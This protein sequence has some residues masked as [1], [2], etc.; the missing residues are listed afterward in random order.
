MAA[1][2]P[3]KY[4]QYLPAIFQRK[5]AFE[6]EPVLG[7]FLA[8]FE[9]RFDEFEHIMAEV[10]RKFSA[11]LAPAGDFLPWLAGWVAHLFD[12]EWDE[13]RRRRFLAGAMEL[14]RWRGTT[15]GLKRYLD[16]WLDLG[17][18]EV[19]IR[20]GRWPAGM[21]IG[22]ASRI[23]YGA[24]PGAT[25][26]AANGP[27]AY[28]ARNAVIDWT[29]H[30][31]YVVDTLASAHLQPSTAESSPPGATGV[32]GTSESLPDGERMQLYFDTDFVQR[33][34]LLKDGDG[35]PAGVRLDYL[36]HDAAG[37]RTPRR[38][39][40]AS[41]ANLKAANR[42][43]VSRRDGL[44]DYY[45]SPGGEASPAGVP[46]AMAGGALL[47]TDVE[48]PYCFIV[49]IRRAFPQPAGTAL[50]E[51]EKAKALS[52]EIEKLGRKV[53]A[54]L[55]AERPAHTEYFVRITPAAG[56][57]G[58]NFMQIGEYSTIGLDTTVA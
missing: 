12:E 4:L 52:V 11:S 35:K 16:L 46:R 26:D 1:S 37:E 15:A 30:N 55:D 23:G 13:D 57:P 36:E 8:P 7:Q 31:Y 43:N 44:V 38:Y 5:P 50:T 42:I 33:I 34:D 17:P 58:P 10:D 14:Y 20:E 54:L 2:Q 25:S 24:G 22:I 39:A 51:A 29:T 47:M 21:Q 28:V 32:N 18:G 27:T 3:S 45:L 9:S 41:P 53:R 56:R 19:E 6:D 49:D 48:R 40:C